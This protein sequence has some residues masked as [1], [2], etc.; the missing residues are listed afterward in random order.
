MGETRLV[1][2]VSGGGRTALNFLD[3]IE[4][5]ELDAS[6]PLVIADDT[7]LLKLP[8]ATEVIIEG[9]RLVIKPDAQDIAEFQHRRELDGLDRS[10]A[11]AIKGP[12]RTADGIPLK[13]DV[14]VNLVTDVEF[15]QPYQ[16]DGIGLYRTEFPFMLRSSLPT[17]GEQYQIFKRVV[18]GMGDRPITI[19]T[20]DVGGDKMMAYYESPHEENP[21]LGLRSIRFSL[22]HRELFR[23]HL[24]AI[25]RAGAGRDIKIM[26]PVISSIE[27]VLAAK[28]SIVEAVGSLIA[29]GIP[30]VTKPKIGVMIEVPSVLEIID[31]IAEEVDFFCLGTNDFVQYMLCVDRTNEMVADFY[32]SHHPAVIRGLN[33]VVQAAQRAGIELSLCGDMA[34]HPEYIPLLIGLGVRRLSVD[35]AYLATTR[36]TIEGVDT[37]Q[38]QEMASKALACRGIDEIADL[39]GIEERYHISEQLK[40]VAI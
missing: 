38:V 18:Q 12:L 31:E 15:S 9:K 30:C 24:R 26:F 40:S 39:L 33:K 37:A 22:E 8:L 27:E 28:R 3:R 20:L 34:H 13:L 32:C 7:K 23:D 16:P 36:K 2:N 5:G 29:E 6:I 4:A 19:R 1:C 10:D 25:L 35:G 11:E 14:N 17:E 21:F